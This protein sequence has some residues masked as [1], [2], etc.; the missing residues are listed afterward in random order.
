MKK[1]GI[2]LLGL[3]VLLIAAVFIGPNFVD[4]NEHK[5]RITSEVRKATGR[6]MTI[7]GDISL[8]LLPAPALSAAKV[9]FANIEG[10]SEP[11]M[12]TLEA[13][14]VRVA[15][16]PLLQGQVKIESV[17]LVKPVILLE[18]L[19]DGRKN[20]EFAPPEK[21]SPAARVK[22]AE[23]D[24]GG[25]AGQIRFDSV[26]IQDGTFIY[27][28]AASGTEERIAHVNAQIGAE[29]LKGPFALSGKAELRG[30]KVTYE[31]GVGR[32]VD[33]GATAINLSL[34]LPEATAR[35]QFG[36]AVSLHQGDITLRGR[37]KSEGDSLAGMM[38]ALA[39][40]GT[41]PVL[42][43]QPFSLETEIS[44]DMQ[45][46]SAAELTLQ[47]GDTA[48]E[49]DIEVALGPPIAARVNL[50]ATR[51]NLD[52]LLAKAAG[53]ARE[54]KAPAVEKPDQPAA[55]AGGGAAG[56]GGA[57]AVSG[58]TL[59]RD[60]NASL[61]V[62]VDALVFRGQVVRQILLSA[63]LAEG[64]IKVSQALALLPGGSDISLTGTLA[65]AGQGGQQELQFAG[66]VEA[67]SD[68]FRSLLDWLGADLA[69]VRPDRL[70][71]MSLTGRIEAGAKQ[72]TLKDIDLRVDVSRM[73]GGITAVLRERPGL[74]IGLAIDKI[75]LDAY[76][77]TG[78]AGQPAQSP[79]KA[80][81]TEGAQETASGGGAAGRAGG[82]LAALDRFDAN[83]DLKIGSLTVKGMAVRDFR[84]DATLRQG[85]MTLREARIGNMAGSS[86]S[87]SGTLAN[88]TS[89]PNV[90]GKLELKVPD[91]A[92]LAKL[93]GLES[94]ALAGLGA[95]DLSGTV[96]GTRERLSLDGKLNAL[97]G[98]FTAAGTLQPLA[99]PP[100]FDLAVT[101]EHP[102]LSKLAKTL[103]KDVALGPGLGGL[104][105]SARVKGTP[106]KVS[107]S[108]LD[109][110]AGPARLSGSLRAD[111]SGPKPVLNDLDLQVV[112]KHPDLS[113]LIRSVAPGA[114]IGGGLGAVDVTAKVSGGMKEIRLSD[115]SG[116][117][118]PV[119]L[120]GSLRA[121]L[122]GPKPVLDDV[123]LQV[124]AKHPE[125]TKLI[126]SLSPGAKVGGK[127]GP[128]DISAKV[129]GGMKEIRL[130]DLS[131]K[132]GP[133]EISGGAS[134]DLSGEKPV[135]K[136]DLVTGVLPVAALMA[137]GGGK[138]DKKS[139]GGASGTGKKKAAR[140]G[141]WSTEPID[142]SA[143]NAVN[144]EVKLKSKALL[145]DKMRLDNA[146]IDVVLTD[147][148]LELRKV[149]GTI[150]GGA[151][152][153]TGRIDAR[154]RLQAGLAV[155]AIEI[156]L[157][158][159]LKAVAQSGRVSGPLDL[160]AS[161]SS[162]GRSQAELVSALSGK[163]EIKGTLN[164]KVKKE[165]QVGSALLGLAGELL[166]QKVQGIRGL[167]DATNVIFNSFAGSP[168]ALQ[169]TFT[170][171]R[172]VV[173][174]SD[175]RLDGRKATALTKGTANLPA[176]RLDSL[177]DIY[178]AENPNTPYL[179]VG[180]RGPLD[181]PSPRLSGLPLQ[182][183]PQAAPSLLSGPQPSGQ[184]QQ[185]PQPA[186]EKL[187]PEDILRKGAKDL[188]KGLFGN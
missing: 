50:S 134:A 164:I 178:L 41:G 157:A 101:A 103:A 32:F 35:L 38:R 104:K 185:Q 128:V 57:P 154:D 61:E 62:A 117:L 54:G 82:G 94:K 163:G 76:L 170:I 16:L 124:A 127:L 107:L 33:E 93:A 68:N 142:L 109:L 162:E 148:L 181:A 100:A 51:L 75:D 184:T 56:A 121:D 46:V 180:L 173:Q 84:L 122:S 25:M 141:R 167:T 156:N 96:K 7:G 44:A 102:D 55:A 28:D 47:L 43:A 168:A 64:R 97:G 175:L 119:Q 74:G 58:P 149:S 53:G 132:L 129:S 130:S 115:L 91:P 2:A 169:G 113:K 126:R 176:W 172:G 138:G 59:P 158:Q 137:A 139:A 63:A 166:G 182:R 123:D 98:R 26:T 20:W 4:W 31:V 92:R 111:L 140:K 155:N 171:K 99:A 60:I 11:A 183:Q 5:G 174:S 114:K 105:L 9:Q 21:Q 17:S 23:S 106:A 143:L 14:R 78:S 151:L 71:R 133:A 83:L 135:F 159:L 152:L 80:G 187:K 186:P 85:T 30:L 39:G 136:A 95:L 161:L 147:G 65:P 81:K 22:P 45:K 110:K 87:F 15:L 8:A 48:I 125:L 42:L 120:S 6:E 116:K 153:V 67:A 144:A 37:F 18:V 179:T 89:Q 165:E 118:G 188:L 145:F 146:V 150:F 24:E 70:R 160:S 3:L 1:L 72:V 66:R 79:G 88:L 13:L 77:S 131:G 73:T 49:G 86:V 69:K 36:G 112:A 19:A 29:S 40:G 12:A 108:E 52:K 27:R 177:T 34:G 10:G 90:D